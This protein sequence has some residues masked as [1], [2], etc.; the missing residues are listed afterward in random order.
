MKITPLSCLPF[1]PEHGRV[2]EPSPLLWPGGMAPSPG[3]GA[4]AFLVLGG[5]VWWGV[6]LGVLETGLGVGVTRGVGAGVRRGVGAGVTRGVGA[7]VTRGVGRGVGF[8]F[9]FG[10]T[11]G[12]AAAVGAAVTV[13]VPVGL[14]T[15]GGTAATA[16]DEAAGA[17]DGNGLVVAGL[18]LGVGSTAGEPPAGE[19]GTGVTGAAAGVDDGSPA[20][21]AVGRTATGPLGRTVTACCWSWKPP[22]P[23]AIVARMRFRTPR[24]R[25]RRTR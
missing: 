25:M 6:G 19:V 11:T 24:L 7:G 8:G 12:V 21:V 23:S 5:F 14:A 10:V 1:P 13:G 3:H 9:G 18:M 4:L 15:G 20:A 2:P 16:V 22:I 17:T